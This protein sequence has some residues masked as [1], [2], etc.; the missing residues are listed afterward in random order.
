MTLKR[1]IGTLVLCLVFLGPLGCKGIRSADYFPLELGQRWHYLIDDEGDI[2]EVTI[3][4]TEKDGERYV[5]QQMVDHGDYEMTFPYSLDENTYVT[6]SDTG[7]T[8]ENDWPFM[9]L[10]FPLDEGKNWWAYRSDSATVLGKVAVSVIAGEFENCY[11]VGYNLDGSEYEYVIWFAPGV[12]IVKTVE[13]DSY[14]WELVSTN[15]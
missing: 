8:G 11:K 3:E 15:F 14:T 9:L 5:L 13:D 6:I 4:A 10:R 12:G 2:G 7:V 1:A